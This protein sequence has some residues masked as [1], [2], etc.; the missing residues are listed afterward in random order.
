ML[1]YHTGISDSFFTWNGER[2]E[3]LPKPFKYVVDLLWPN[4]ETDQAGLFI[5]TRYEGHDDDQVQEAFLE[6]NHKGFVG[7]LEIQT[8]LPD[9]LALVQGLKKIET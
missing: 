1:E 6:I 9:N 8:Y 5:S 2:L 3:E 7:F 4:G